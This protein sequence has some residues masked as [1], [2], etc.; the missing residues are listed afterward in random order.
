MDLTALA[1]ST[2]FE[3][4]RQ[5]AKISRLLAQLAGY[6]EIETEIIEQA[7]LFHDIGKDAIPSGILN[8]PG[9]LTPQEFAI[10]KSHTV[11]GQERLSQA[12]QTLSAAIIVAQQHHERLDGS[13]YLSMEG[14]DIHP[15]AKLIAVAD[16]FDALVSRRSYKEPWSIARTGTYLQELSGIQ[17]ECN[18]V[19]MLL[20]NMDQVLTLYHKDKCV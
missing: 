19:S 8:K 12:V 3:H 15:Y 17:F 10:I 13:G 18:I 16:V 1:Q 9:T 5:V 11:I 7:A 2:K 6:S 4:S 14:K 20:G